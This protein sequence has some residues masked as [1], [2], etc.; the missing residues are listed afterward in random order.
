[1]VRLTGFDGGEVMVQPS[2][3]V[4][5]KDT[6]KPDHD[7]VCSIIL[8]TGEILLVPN[9]ASVVLRALQGSQP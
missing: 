8:V 9:R 6:R 3:V 2:A 7:P 4:S 5:L 1:M